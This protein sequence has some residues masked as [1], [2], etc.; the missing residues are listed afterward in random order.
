MNIQVAMSIAQGLLSLAT[1]TGLLKPEVGAMLKQA[2]KWISAI[3]TANKEGR[4]ISDAEMK[5][6]QKKSQEM[7]QDIL[8]RLNG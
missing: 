7:T 8:K 6:L 1:T 5:A 4:D 2:T 3:K